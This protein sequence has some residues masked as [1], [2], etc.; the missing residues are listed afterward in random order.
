M[1]TSAL[2]GAKIFGFFEIFD[3]S[4]RRREMETVQIFW[5]RRR[6]ILCGRL[7]WRAP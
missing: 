6:V 3:V 4:P 7:L 1:R 2:Y 5:T